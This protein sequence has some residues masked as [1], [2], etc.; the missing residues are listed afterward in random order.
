M[1]AFVFKSSQVRESVFPQTN[2]L[3]I[4]AKLKLIQGQLKYSQWRIEVISK[5]AS[6][7]IKVHPSP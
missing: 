6:V 1:R 2:T 3:I 5:F 7:L 4:Y